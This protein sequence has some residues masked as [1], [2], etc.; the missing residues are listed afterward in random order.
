MSNFHPHEVVGRAS[1]T[2]L[3]VGENSNK[4]TKERTK[5][6]SFETLED[7][8]SRVSRSIVF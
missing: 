8:G 3:R 2:Q 5:G 7:K 1:E 6:L 4:I